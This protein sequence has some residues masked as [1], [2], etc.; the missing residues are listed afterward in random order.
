M[1]LKFLLIIFSVSTFLFSC[2]NTGIKAQAKEQNDI[3]P[4][5]ATII[6]SYYAEAYTI[7]TVLSNKDLKI[8][9]KSDLVGAKDTTVFIKALQPSDTLRQISE[10][11]L[12]LLKDYYENPCIEDGLQVTVMIEKDSKR[13]VVHLSNYY[14]EDVGKIIYL[15]NSLVPK[16]YKVWYNKEKLITGYNRCKGIK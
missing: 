10:I 15:I 1:S 8:I 5:T 13:K 14:Q 7:M 3:K 9:F 6:N 16:Q 11:D 4:F 2:S 12:S